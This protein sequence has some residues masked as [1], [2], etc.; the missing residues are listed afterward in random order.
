[1]QKKI[2]SKKELDN[3]DFSLLLKNKVKKLLKTR[4]IKSEINHLKHHFKTDK[5]PLRANLLQ[6]DFGIDNSLT[7]YCLLQEAG[8]KLYYS[9]KKLAVML[10]PRGKK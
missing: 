8:F 2:L 4:R 3:L 9:K 6:E 10:K 5:W 7:F 1:M